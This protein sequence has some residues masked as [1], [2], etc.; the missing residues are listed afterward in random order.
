MKPALLA[1]LLLAEPPFNQN[2]IVIDETLLE[3]IILDGPG[4]YH[5][6]R[7]QELE[8][9]FN[10]GMNAIRLHASNVRLPKR[11]FG[12]GDAPG[13]HGLTLL[14]L[15]GQPADSALL[16][17]INRHIVRERAFESGN[18]YR[19]WGMCSTSGARIGIQYHKD[20]RY[21]QALEIAIEANG[22][23]HLLRH[24]SH[25][26]WRQLADTAT[27]Q[28][29]DEGMHPTR[30]ER[31]R[32][33][34]NCPREIT[35]TPVRTYRP[36]ELHTVVVNWQDEASGLIRG[37]VLQADI[38]GR[39]ARQSLLNRINRRIPPGASLWPIYITCNGDSDE[40]YIRYYHTL[41]DHNPVRV[42]PMDSLEPPHM[43][44]ISLIFEGKRQRLFIE[45]TTP[46]PDDYE[47]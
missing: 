11:G 4:G 15:N 13:G 46:Y 1:L 19:A 30:E 23:G 42:W 34:A 32:L 7:Y 38:D 45:P 14:T 16:H 47:E 40:F 39:P 35:P 44:Q 10:C 3:N 18:V 36:T 9:S 21:P 31:I 2:G 33:L 6:S 28:R 5:S 20:Y 24:Y 43:R 22:R 41:H 17:A 8:Y 29:F 12:D 37:R 26:T 27:L 25:G